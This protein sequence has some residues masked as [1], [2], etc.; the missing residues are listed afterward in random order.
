M[1]KAA[2]RATTNAAVAN[3]VDLAGQLGAAAAEMLR[4]RR[5]PA[6][7]AQ[8]KRRAARRRVRAWSFGVVGSGGATAVVAVV[9]LP[10]NVSAGAVLALI[11]LTAL[12]VYCIVGVVRSV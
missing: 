10:G 11:F 9:A 8:K 7:I 6:V 3:G 1:R 2:V 4:V 5:D 12:L